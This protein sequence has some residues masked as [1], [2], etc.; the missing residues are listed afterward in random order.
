M[1]TAG[2]INY[3]YSHYLDKN[4]GNYYFNQG[5]NEQKSKIL[6]GQLTRFNKRVKII[7][8]DDDALFKLYG[9][10]VSEE[11]LSGLEQEIFIPAAQETGKITGFKKLSA[12]ELENFEASLDAF[13][14]KLASLVAHGKSILKD[15]AF[16]I[17]RDGPQIQSL[18][19]EMYAEGGEGTLA[20]YPEAMEIIKELL[21]KNQS[22]VTFNKA[23]Q[24]RLLTSVRKLTQAVAALES[25]GTTKKAPSA[26]ELSLINTLIGKMGGWA[27]DARGI[28]TEYAVADVFNKSPDIVSRALKNINIEGVV[29]KNTTAETLGTAKGAG[30]AGKKKGDV[31]LT[32]NIDK[33]G[34]GSLN[35]QWEVSLKRVSVRR[36]KARVHLV[37]ETPFAKLVEDSPLRNSG[38]VDYLFNT[39]GGHEDE[40][41]KEGELSSR[42][43][44][45]VTQIVY[46]SFLN[47]IAGT[48]PAEEG[49]DRVILLVVNGK[50]FPIATVLE[51]LIE[52][53]GK[54]IG[55]SRFPRKAMAGTNQWIDDPAGINSRNLG[56]QRSK[57]AESN[58]Y[59]TWQ[60]KKMNI[61]LGLDMK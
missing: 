3:Y 25:L 9:V 23:D 30:R 54:G 61:T 59:Q 51:H 5:F 22:I 18:M 52:N 57:I 43:N 42:W 15:M 10:L 27:I 60:N 45:A 11:G 6:R 50:A 28:L 20:S 46:S 37:K 33:N 34:N 24:Q 40:Y 55:A 12:A 47:A 7:T 44:Q 48:S 16:I 31:T 26:E 36:D 32:T 14:S 38:F 4:K 29:I 53:Q 39:A 1:L 21:S 58:I 17:E 2:Y 41:I 56:L 19:K 8:K 13:L 49:G 35:L